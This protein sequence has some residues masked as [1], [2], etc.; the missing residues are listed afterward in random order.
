MC[1]CTESSRRPCGQAAFPAASRPR[2]GRTAT[3]SLQDGSAW[4]SEV[5][6][7]NTPTGARTYCPM[8]P[9]EPQ[10]QEGDTP[11][12]AGSRRRPQA[13]FRELGNAVRTENRQWLSGGPVAAPA[14]G[15][16]RDVT[17]GA[18]GLVGSAEQRTSGRGPR[19]A[20][21]GLG[22]RGIPGRDTRVRWRAA[23]LR[24]HGNARHTAS[25]AGAPD[26]PTHSESAGWAQA[27]PGAAAGIPADQ[28]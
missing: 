23:V 13:R 15:A 5:P 10:L 11:A 19:G 24:S 26:H 2:R 3:R 25:P 1:S 6:G 21:W 22:D 12:C 8:T 27:G 17:T 14:L 18:R 28:G 20:G 4:C 7:S 9:D 16:G